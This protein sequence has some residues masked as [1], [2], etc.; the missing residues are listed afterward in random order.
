M[1]LC[2]TSNNDPRLRFGLVYKNQPEKGGVCFR[3]YHGFMG[4]SVDII[5]AISKGFLNLPNRCIR[6]DLM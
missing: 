3:E 2:N 6:Y 4:L 1:D 5:D